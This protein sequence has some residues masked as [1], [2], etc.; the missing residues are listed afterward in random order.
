MAEGKGGADGERRLLH[1][2]Q[3]GKGRMTQGERGPYLHLFRKK[4]LGEAWVMVSFCCLREVVR[5]SRQEEG[6]RR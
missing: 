3:E 6:P 2:R 5:Y 1:D 4:S